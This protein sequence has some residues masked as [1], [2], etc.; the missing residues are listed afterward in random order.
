M[1]TIHVT[2]GILHMAES[3]ASC[4]QCGTQVGIVEVDDRLQKSKRFYVRHTCRD[5]GGKMDVY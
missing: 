2:G 5:C 1:K 4:P 3:K